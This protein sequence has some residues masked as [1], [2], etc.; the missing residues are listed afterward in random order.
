MGKGPSVDYNAMKAAKTAAA[1][2]FE[3][4]GV[5]AAGENTRR[6]IAAA[7]SRSK[8]NSFFTSMF[9]SSVG[10]G[11]QNAGKNTLG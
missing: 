2:T 10:N 3:D 7:N 4:D 1:T 9:G 8:A 11:T 5:Q 6:R